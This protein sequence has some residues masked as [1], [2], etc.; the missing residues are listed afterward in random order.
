MPGFDGRPRGNE[1]GKRAR[2]LSCL[3]LETSRFPG[4]FEKFQPD[5]T[6]ISM[7]LFAGA[8]ICLKIDSNP[9]FARK[10]FISKSWSAI[11]A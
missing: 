7:V 9:L 8:V 1:F 10:I 3:K 6:L 11:F 5:A 4:A 2:T